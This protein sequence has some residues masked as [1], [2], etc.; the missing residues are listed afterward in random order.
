MDSCIFCRIIA[1][2]I[3]SMR[4]YEDEQC[5]AMLD[6]NPA[7]SGH[8][9]ILPREHHKDITEMDEALLGHVL[10]VAKEIG[11]RQ[12]ERLNAEGFNI[13]QNNG[14]AA[15]QTVPHFHVHVIPR[16]AGGPQMVSWEPTEPEDGALSAVLEKLK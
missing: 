8:T 1:G 5:I 15:G 12:M 2:D 7:S 11:K 6:I 3:P 9:L 4:V 10:S 13:V 16:Y 14:A